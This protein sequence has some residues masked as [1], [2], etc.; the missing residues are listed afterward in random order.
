MSIVLSIVAFL[1]IFSLLILVHETGHFVAAKRSGIKVLEFGFG[2]PPRAWGK[3]IG[4]T[5]YSINWIPFGGFVKMYGE[6]PSSTELLKN[7]ESFIG[8]PLRQRIKVVVAGVVMNFLFAWILL[9]LGFGFGMQPLLVTSDDAISAINSGVL[10]LTYGVTVK[11]V[12]DRSVAYEV[13][14]EPGDIVTALDGS[15][16]TSYDEFAAF[17]GKGST[18]EFSIDVVRGDI[19]RNVQIDREYDEAIGVTFEKMIFLTHPVVKNVKPGS[20]SAKAGFKKGDVILSVNG[21][22]VYAVPDYVEIVRNNSVLNYRVLRG[23]S[24]KEVTVDLSKPKFAYITDVGAGTPAFSAGFRVGDVITKV[25]SEP[26]LSI[27]QI[28]WLGEQSAGE[29]VLY[30]VFRDNAEID[31]SAVPNM[32]GKIGVGLTSVFYSDNYDLDL[33]IDIVPAS[34]MEIYDV[35]Y[36]FYAAP[37]HALTESW[38]LTKFTASMFIDAIGSLVKKFAVPEGMAGPVGIAKLTHVFVQEG[39][40]ALVRFTA[41]LSLSLAVVNILPFPALDGGRFL[42]F[43]V[44]AVRGKRLNPVWESRIHAIGFLI[45]MLLITVITWGDIAG[46]IGD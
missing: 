21:E 23:F 26:V 12:E 24:E 35:E 1:V 29:D 17:F 39:I 46:L 40:M 31:L 15:S 27:E 20:L 28:L 10:D 16:I 5:I 22:S 3:K 41:L 30:T 13:G 36:P 2:L 18:D 14:L 38:R 19:S 33:S 32:K 6:D 25:N 45:L 37:Y 42:F 7:P 4:D 43:V 11:E 44:E 34:V 8:K 9:T